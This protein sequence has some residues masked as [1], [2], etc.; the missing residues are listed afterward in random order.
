MDLREY[1]RKKAELEQIQRN[2]DRIEG[3]LDREQERL[4]SDY[5]C[6][7]IKEARKLLEA[8]ERKLERTEQEYQDLLSAFDNKWGGKLV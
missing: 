4:K 7:S 6:D 1:Q 3:V 5:N 2:A 8:E